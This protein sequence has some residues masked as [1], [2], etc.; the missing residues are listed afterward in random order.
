LPTRAIQEN[1]I[2]EQA[3]RPRYWLGAGPVFLTGTGAAAQSYGSVEVI[4]SF[5]I[6]EPSALEAFEKVRIV[7]VADR[8]ALWSCGN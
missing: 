1:T 4:T 6:P 2:D 3:G 5:P 8:L 7:E